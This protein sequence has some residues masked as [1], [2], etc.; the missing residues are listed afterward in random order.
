MSGEGLF[1]IGLMLGGMILVMYVSYFSASS[2]QNKW[3]VVLGD[4][5][6][7]DELRLQMSMLIDSI[8]DLDF[9]YDMGKV[10]EQVYIEQRKM[11]LGRAVGVLNR[12]DK[13]ETE[14][15]AA[16]LDIEAAVLRYRHQMQSE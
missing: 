1:F 11:L 9:D 2:S 7:T 4:R 13:A 16:S 12:L 15:T 5:A 6:T 3:A 14:N 10:P 8:C